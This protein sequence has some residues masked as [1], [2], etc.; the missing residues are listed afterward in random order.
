MTDKTALR[1][2]K[3]KFGKGG[4]IKKLDPDVPHRCEIRKRSRD[5]DE[6]LGMG[7]TWEHAFLAAGVTP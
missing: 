2:A 7:P 4:Y 6:I 1:K 5:A 3:E